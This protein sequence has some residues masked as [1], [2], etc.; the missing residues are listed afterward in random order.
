ME[1]SSNTTHLI[2]RLELE[3]AFFSCEENI[4]ENPQKSE[5]RKSNLLFKEIKIKK[6]LTVSSSNMAVRKP[7]AYQLHVKPHMQYREWK[8]FVHL[9][10]KWLRVS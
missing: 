1:H 3:G 7:A 5:L 8:S 6:P 9:L 2:P 4:L 10:I